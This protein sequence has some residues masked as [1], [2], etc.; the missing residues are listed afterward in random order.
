LTLSGHYPSVF[1]YREAW[2]SRCTVLPQFFRVF[3]LANMKMIQFRHFRYLYALLVFASCCLGLGG[4]AQ[5]QP[6]TLRYE[7]EIKAFEK[8]DQANPP[9]KNAIL[10][11]GSSSIRRWKSLAKDF[12][13][14]CV[15][16]RGFGGS[17]ISDL[18]YYSDRIV[19]PYQP[20]LIV[21]YAG[22]ND[23]HDGKKP[24]QVLEDFKAFVAKIHQALPQARIDFISIGPSPARWKDVDAVRAGFAAES[25]ILCVG[26][27][28]PG[29][30]GL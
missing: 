6:N 29:C 3:R 21:F 28:S 13:G 18:I 26:Q 22:V 9:S 19:I 5:P 1:Y 12:P 2:Q 30:Q 17:Q 24:E 20:R 10:F 27:T 23:V 11:I 16:N 8:A 14:R 7:K 25:G 15:I 4:C